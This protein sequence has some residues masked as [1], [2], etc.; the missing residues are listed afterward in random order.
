[1]NLTFYHS[2]IDQKGA[3]YSLVVIGNVEGDQMS[4]PLRVVTG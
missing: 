4:A 1:M 3:T 2:C